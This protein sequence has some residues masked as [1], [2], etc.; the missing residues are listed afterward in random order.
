MIHVSK[1]DDQPET[2]FAMLYTHAGMF[3]SSCDN[4][5][6]H[7]MCCDVFTNMLEFLLPILEYLHLLSNFQTVCSIVMVIP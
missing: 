1:T 2:A 5:E 3:Q 6:S 4:S 7:A